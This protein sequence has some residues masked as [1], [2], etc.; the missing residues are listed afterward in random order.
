MM[1]LVLTALLAINVSKEVLDG[2]V[3]V[4]NGLI[5]SGH[6]MEE[7]MRSN[8][9]GFERSA[10]NMPGR[11]MEYWKQAESVRQMSDKLVSYISH[12]KANVIAENEGLELEH[13]LGKDE[14]G[15]DTVLN[16]RYVKRLDNI[17]VI[18]QMLVGGE[19]VQP[20]TGPYTAVELHENLAEFKHLLTAYVSDRSPELIASLD[21]KFNFNDQVDAS[22]VTQ[23]WEAYH[24]NE[25]PIA[26]GVT[27]LS[28]IQNDVRQA[29]SDVVKWLREQVNDEVFAN[30]VM[31]PAVI[32]PSNFVVMGDSF[33]A[34]IFLA[35]YDDKNPPVVELAL[36][37]ATIDEESLEIHGPKQVLPVGRDGKAK[38][39]SFSDRIGEFE[40]RGIIKLQAPQGEE[41]FLFNSKHRVVQP[42]LV[43]SPTKMN[44][45]YRHV[46]NP[47]DL[48]VAGY[49]SDQIEPVVDNG[50]I[51]RLNG[52][53]VV[54]PGPA[55]KTHI[56]VQ[57]TEEDGSIRVFGPVEFRARNL[58]APIAFV[59]GRSAKD[60]RIAKSR[61]TAASRVYAALP[62][63][64]FNVRYEIVSCK[65]YGRNRTGD[66]IDILLEGGEFNEAAKAYIQTLNN[67][68]MFVI[69][70][71]KAR[72]VGTQS[73]VYDIGGLSLRVIRD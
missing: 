30:T 49:T 3:L 40:Q 17:D 18:S 38:L 39:S 66:A 41:R 31:T 22:G 23:K 61:L 36:E 14:M 68:Q 48:S 73:P 57:V 29:E 21:R 5:D 58:P 20:R 4:N 32:T 43:A 56:R 15:Q 71:V 54:R 2:F 13:V 72:V 26:A 6:S 8:Y 34:D 62:D 47:M 19:S 70:N 59:G 11:A 53:F 16:M 63:T 44:V 42:A 25:V 7:E 45:L 50:T 65:L 24:F 51:Q 28:K 60:Q 10:N 69:G 33:H 12:I 1:Y 27:V 55:N 46:N 35:A 52:E 37:G 67:R 64:D 9:I